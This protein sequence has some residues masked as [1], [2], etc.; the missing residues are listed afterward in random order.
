MTSGPKYPTKHD[1]TFEYKNR[2]YVTTIEKGRLLFVARKNYVQ[3][4]WEVYLW[5]LQ[6]NLSY[7]EAK[8]GFFVD[9]N[10]AKNYIRMIITM[11]EPRQNN[12]AFWLKNFATKTGKHRYG[13]QTG[14]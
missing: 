8:L 10:D 3:K 12:R 2:E 11:R 4:G 9:V 5:I 7:V 6:E 13:A 1:V 14:E